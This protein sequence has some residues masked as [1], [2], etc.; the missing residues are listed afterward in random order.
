MLAEHGLRPTK[1]LGQH[2]LVSQSIID[3]IVL[4]TGQVKS[5]LEVGPGP[6]LLTR[7]LTDEVQHVTAVEIDKS[8]ESALTSIAHRA[9]II[10]GDALQTDL[11]LILKDLEPP[12]AIVS[13]M[14]YNIT[15]PLLDAFCHCKPHIVC[16]VLMMQAEVAQKIMAKP[17]DSNR[18]AI[19]VNLQAHFQIKRICKAPP[20]AF[21]PPPKVVSTVLHFEPKIYEWPP[22][23]EDIFRAGF[24]SPRKTLLNNLSLL[25]GSDEARRRLVSA[26]LSESIR[27]HQLAQED[28]CNLAH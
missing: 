11:Q 19:S 7:A 16:M 4:A 27:A 23:V 14:P 21:M 24:R 17:G 10:W 5:V 9:E 18:G 13:N 1:K 2:F 28:W 25:I 26:K 3:Q 22:G 8:L 6:G 15:G 12:R 20:G